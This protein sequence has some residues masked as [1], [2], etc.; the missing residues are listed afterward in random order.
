M[1]YLSDLKKLLS[2]PSVYDSSTITPNTP[3]GKA[4]QKAL[5]FMQDLAILNGFE[6]NT[7]D[8]HAIS[9]Q[10]GHQCER[11]D[12]VS[13]LDVVQASDDWESD[14]FDPI[15]KDG[16]IIAR[17]TQDM[18]SLALLMFYVLR[19]IKRENIVLRRQVRLVYGADEERTMKDIEHYIKIEGEP[20][21]AFTPDG[22][23]PL[24]I[25]EKGAIMWLVKG[26]C[27]S[28]ITIN[29]GIQCNVVSPICIVE[30]PIKYLERINE[31]KN[32]GVFD[33]NVIT[34]KSIELVFN[35]IASHASKPELGV[36]ANVE[37]LKFLSSITDSQTIKSL[38]QTFQS[39]YGEGCNIQV[40]TSEMGNLTL[41]L[42]IL[43]IV[44][45]KV[46]CEVDCRYPIHAQSD[47]MTHKLQNKL[48]PLLVS[49]PYDAKPSLHS[50]ESPYIK[51]LLETYKKW[52]NEDL[53]P[54]V[55]GGVS[56]S[57]VMKNCVAFGPMRLDEESLAH[58]KNESIELDYL[59]SLFS[60]YKN[61]IISL[62]NQGE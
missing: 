13:H 3:Y 15:I 48:S 14:P 20:D 35:G 16:R 55:S 62:A 53:T 28:E 33:I 6:T 49:C 31:M 58:Q 45:Q 10:L 9:I 4:I 2:I 41:N 50:M 22:Y 11:I 12:V 5:D 38:Y 21:F 37:A 25:G 54:I 42:G 18:K 56:Y 7:Y 29:G 17:G 40:Q 24:S 60:V 47:K 39:S 44:N 30:V 51:T 8:G 52:S 34:D 61:A 43:K 26:E 59:N 46:Y 27:D 32:T 57:K 36:N 23:F 19:D 1:N